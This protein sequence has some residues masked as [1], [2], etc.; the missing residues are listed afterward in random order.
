MYTEYAAAAVARSSL[1]VLKATCA[2][3]CA[4]AACVAATV[5]VVVLLLLHLRLAFGLCW[6]PRHAVGALP[7][8]RLG[9][10]KPFSNSNHFRPCECKKYS[11]SSSCLFLLSP[12]F[13]LSYKGADHTLPPDTPFSVINAACL[14]SCSK[15]TAPLRTRYARRRRRRRQR[16]AARV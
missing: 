5:V 8:H 2:A 11:S 4:A 12:N 15:L 3:T 6:R 10:P 9:S 1:L 13:Q 16:L 14:R 7:L